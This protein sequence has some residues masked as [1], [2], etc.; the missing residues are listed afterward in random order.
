MLTR[1][2]QQFCSI[3]DGTHGC[4][5][6]IVD[7]I[8]RFMSCHARPVACMTGAANISKEG[9][10][11]KALQMAIQLVPEMHCVSKHALH[12]SKVKF[13]L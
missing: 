6:I 7:A 2:L 8:D 12:P 4:L 9:L 3:V 10:S 1:L 5:Y 13:S 11:S